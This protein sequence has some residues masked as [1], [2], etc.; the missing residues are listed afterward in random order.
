MHSG[1][2]SHDDRWHMLSGSCDC[3]ARLCLFQRWCYSALLWS[4]AA[5]HYSSNNLRSASFTD[6]RPA[7]CNDGQQTRKA[8]T[9]WGFEGQKRQ[10]LLRY[11][12]KKSLHTE[13]E[14]KVC[15]ISASAELKMP[16]PVQ[17]ITLKYTTSIKSEWWQRN[18]VTIVP[19]TASSTQ[20]QSP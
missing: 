4:H 3:Q 15:C 17:G 7:Q 10:G 2:T 18:Y 14:A 8:A 13:L 12:R 1:H 11:G 16:S 9:Q 6:Q 20:S 5:V 19:W